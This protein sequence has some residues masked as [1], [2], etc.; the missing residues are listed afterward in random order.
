M[1]HP[2]PFLQFFGV[3]TNHLN[4]FKEKILGPCAEEKYSRKLLTS[5][6]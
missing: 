6:I 1:F 2:T 3:E 5:C 4:L